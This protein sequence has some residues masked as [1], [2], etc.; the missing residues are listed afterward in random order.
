LDAAAAQ[1]VFISVSRKR[2]E[3]SANMQIK[4]KADNA[5]AAK[6]LKVFDTKLGLQYS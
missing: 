6:S 1:L 5:L 2:D 4:T 3:R